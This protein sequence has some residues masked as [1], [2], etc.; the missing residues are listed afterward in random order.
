MDRDIPVANEA[1]NVLEEMYGPI[2]KTVKR[3]EAY[4]LME[5]RKTITR[6]KFQEFFKL[7]N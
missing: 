1:R 4:M 3:A 5:R 2:G 6:E 7:D